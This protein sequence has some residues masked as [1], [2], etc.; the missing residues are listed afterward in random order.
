MIDVFSADRVGYLLADILQYME[1]RV[2][3]KAK[4]YQY[5]KYSV[6]EASGVTPVK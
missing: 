6:P 3:R 1:N 5:V 2:F 4:I